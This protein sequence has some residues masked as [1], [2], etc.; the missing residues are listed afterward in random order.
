MLRSK[1]ANFDA[2][3]VSLSYLSR[4]EKIRGDTNIISFLTDEDGI[5]QQGTGNVIDVVNKFYISLYKH[6]N[7]DIGEQNHFFQNISTRLSV[8]DKDFLDSPFTIEELHL[9]LKEIKNGK[10]PG[11]DSISKEILNFFWDELGPLFMRCL[12]EIKSMKHLSESQKRALISLVFKKG[13][14]DLLK[15]QRPISCINVDL[16]TVTKLLARRLSKVID[17]LIGKNQKCLPGRQI[18]TNLH[19]LQDFIHYANSKDIKAAVLFLDQET[20]FDRMSHSFMI[21]TLQHFGFGNDFIDWIRIIYTDCSARVK[22]NGYFST[23]I[24]IERGVRQGCPLSSL[25]YVLCIEVLS[26]EFQ[27]NSSIVGFKYLFQE[28]KNN[29]YADDVSIIFTEMPSLDEIFNV[30]KKFEKATNAKINI[31]KTEGLWIGAWRN[32]TDTPLG[33]KWVNTMVKNLGVFFGNNRTDCEARNFE[34]IKEKIKNKLTYWGGK[35]IS[36]KGKI[37][38]INTF[39]LPKLWHVSEIHNISLNDK[40]DIKGMISAFIWKGNYHQRSLSG[41]EADYHE[42]GL[43]LG[44]IDKKINAM[45]VKWL[46]YV[47]N[48]DSNQIEFFLANALISENCSKMGIDLLKG[49][50]LKYIKTI[51]NRFYKNALLAWLKLKVFFGPRNIFSIKNLWI[52]ENILLKNDDGRVYKPPAN[53]GFIRRRRDMPYYFRDLPFPI[54]NRH[55]VDAEFIRN[56]N[57]SFENMEW[58]DDNFYYID[59]NNEK[60]DIKNM[61]FKDIYWLQF[62]N[63]PIDQPYKRRWVSIFPNITFD[64]VFI[65]ENVHSNMLPYK[66]IS[67]Q[68]VDDDKFKL[69]FLIHIK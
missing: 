55:P 10:S 58:F 59:Y 6:E 69:H 43:R 49:Y 57:A 21:K 18:G 44:N 2:N 37:R 66:T 38:V 23:R 41:L 8:E 14:R 16:K 46:T 68:F 45:R 26:L 17:K 67:E 53:S 13:R 35:G 42:G 29:G 31:S 30:L 12:D 11:E 50:S 15:N 62:N 25:L 34:E 40:E 54:I 28:H 60:N 65:W 63:D 9:S 20:A 7:E 22:V 1:I 32:R 47:L 52:Y 36:L 5:L 56:I 48:S 4:L 64:W 61:N 3:E 39:I 19:T 33:I 27:S 51:K 24:P